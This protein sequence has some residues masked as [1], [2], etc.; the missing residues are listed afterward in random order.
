M[1]SVSGVASALAAFGKVAALGKLAGEAGVRAVAEDVA[2]FARQM[3]PVD[4][5]ELRDSIEVTG[6]GVV[7]GTDHAVYV[8]FGTFKMTAEPFLRPAADEADESSA[9][10]AATAVFRSL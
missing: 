5:G 10:V 7:A 9:A 8:E 1:I 2:T 4:T 6:E 3:V